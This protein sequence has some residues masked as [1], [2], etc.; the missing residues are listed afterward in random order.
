MVFWFW[1]FYNK[2]IIIKLLCLLA[3][4]I[5]GNNKGPI[6]V[7]PM[8]VMNKRVLIINVKGS[9]SG[10]WSAVYCIGARSYMYMWGVQ[11]DLTNVNLGSTEPLCQLV[12]RRWSTDQVA[13]CNFHVKSVGSGIISRAL[14]N[15]DFIPPVFCNLPPGYYVNTDKSSHKYN[16]Y[17]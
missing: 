15:K 6:K 7:K 5:A 2:A 10:L 9:V 14:G 17:H 1:Q 16:L 12:T 11:G 8:T 4:V 13:L 3:L